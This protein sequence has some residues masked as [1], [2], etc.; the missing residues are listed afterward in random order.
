ETA[1]TKHAD[2][3]IAKFSNPFIQDS[4]ARGLPDCALLS[5]RVPVNFLKWMRDF[6]NLFQD[7]ATYSFLELLS[8]IPDIEAAW[9]TYK[10]KRGITARMGA[11]RMRDGD[12]DSSK[13]H[14]QLYWDFVKC[15]CEGKL[16]SWRFY[17][18]AKALV[19]HMK[20]NEDEFMELAWARLD[21]LEPGLTTETVVPMLRS[22]AA[23]LASGLASMESR[24]N[25]KG[26]VPMVMKA[27]LMEGFEPCAL[28][29]DGQGTR[30]PQK[31]PWIF[32][33]PT[34]TC[35]RTGTGRPARRVDDLLAC[36]KYGLDVA[37]RDGAF[38][39]VP[40]HV[41]LAVACRVVG[42]G[43][44]LCCNTS[45]VVNSRTYD[46]W[47]KLREVLGDMIIQSHVVHIE[48][49]GSSESSGDPAD[50]ILRRVLAITGCD[51]DSAVSDDSIQSFLAGPGASS[52]MVEIF[53]AYGPAQPLTLSHEF[54]ALQ[55]NA[56]EALNAAKVGDSISLDSA[57]TVIIHCVGKV[58]LVEWAHF[59]LLV[60]ECV[61][62]TQSLPA[63]A[64][65]VFG[66]AEA[67][68][69]LL[70]VCAKYVIGL[71]LNLCTAA[72]AIKLEGPNMEIA[73]QLLRNQKVVDVLT[74]VDVACQN[75]LSQWTTMWTK[76]IMLLSGYSGATGG[77]KSNEPVT[78]LCGKVH[79][80]RPADTEK[81]KEAADV[82]AT[83]AAGAAASEALALIL[84]GA[85]ESAHEIAET[86]LMKYSAI[87]GL[88]DPAGNAIHLFRVQ[89]IL[90][91]KIWEAAGL[92]SRESIAAD[93]SEK[94]TRLHA[95]PGCAAGKLELSF[96]GQVASVWGVDLFVVPGARSS[97]TGE[98]PSPAWLA[99]VTNENEDANMQLESREVTVSIDLRD[100]GEIR[101][102]TVVDLE[103]GV[104]VPPESRP[105]SR[106]VLDVALSVPVLA[107]TKDLNQ[108]TVLK[109]FVD[110]MRRGAPAA[111][112]A[113]GLAGGQGPTALAVKRR[114]PAIKDAESG[115]SASAGSS[116]SGSRPRQQPQQSGGG[117]SAAD[118]SSIRHLLR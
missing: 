82:E 98:C 37:R 25:L 61:A 18:I 51:E 86:S 94:P 1:V 9:A 28:L 73:S 58:F 14:Q 43:F 20:K 30:A 113:D 78:E 31:D 114:L 68:E 32:N 34:I 111:E 8:E 24:L 70:G 97:L 33:R 13:S 67:V 36:L 19:H 57:L 91:A 29:V 17:D 79:E 85:A 117:I 89:K 109:Y 38:A 4:C 96:G 41:K 44:Q 54:I 46:S 26:D 74:E 48:L 47:S 76:C 92:P 110:K 106:E 7:G 72:D 40:A 5:W 103:D 35:S 27:L 108:S 87:W 118:A 22:R 107:L 77:L 71:L 115:T 52:G 15:N 21:W 59:W 63:C 101:G 6:H 42:I 23:M 2:G 65:D 84:A 112:G 105:Q 104:S 3:S 62:Q 64:V 69:A 81:V 83:P 75:S 102:S 100:L 55:A 80:L 11:G 56:Y 95:P 12:D 39:A 49:A 66:S 50:E 53:A 99:G 45:V 93:V 60:C 88:R 10:Q 90:G 16:A 116:S